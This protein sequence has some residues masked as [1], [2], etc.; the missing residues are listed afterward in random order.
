[1]IDNVCADYVMED[2]LKLKVCQGRTDMD[3]SE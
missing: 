1:M 3:V 2:L